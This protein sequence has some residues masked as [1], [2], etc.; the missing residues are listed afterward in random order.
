MR[1]TTAAP[2]DR[3]QLA[4]TARGL[5]AESYP[6]H[7]AANTAAAWGATG[8]NSSLG[9]VLVGL[10]A[11]DVI[12]SL[13]AYCAATGSS[14]TLVKYALYDKTGTFL[15]ATADLSASVAAN[16]ILTGALTSTYTVPADDG[17]YL[18]GLAIS[19]VTQPTFYRQASTTGL[20]AVVGSGVRPCISASGLTDLSAN[21]TPAASNTS[22]WM[23]AS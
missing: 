10:R 17:Y 5:I 7:A 13:T 15:R 18:V 2:K 9:G 8:V 21:V 20:S 19:S 4:L 16:T 1:V 22:W 23:A 12:T 11:G 3:T 6:V 14:T